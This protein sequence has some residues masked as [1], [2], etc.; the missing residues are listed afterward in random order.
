MI[1]FL[2]LAGT[3]TS[4]RV[5]GAT[6]WPALDGWGPS[7]RVGLAAMLALTASA[8]FGSRRRD[9]VRMV[10]PALPRPELLVTITGIAEL[11][12]AV[13]LLLPG[14][15][16]AA[17]VV[18]VAL[19]VAMFPANVQAARAGVGIGGRPPTPL[20]ARTALQAVFIVAAVTA[21]FAGGAPS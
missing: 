18:L 4:A 10:P 13:A 20:V 5:V 17:A 12:V 9:L 15:A 8:H 21:A 2:V 16:P 19:L 14:A 6:A 3:T 7:L 1:P 11:L